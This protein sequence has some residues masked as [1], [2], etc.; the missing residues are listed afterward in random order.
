LLVRFVPG[1][2]L[3][4]RLLPLAIRFGLGVSLRIILVLSVSLPLL[5]LSPLLPLAV[6]FIILPPLLSHPIRHLVRP[7]H[8]HD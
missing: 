4:Q 1:G 5:F 3:V 7:N 6:V 8:G 2:T